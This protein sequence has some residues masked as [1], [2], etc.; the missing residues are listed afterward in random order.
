MSDRAGTPDDLAES[1]G[2]AAGQGPGAS[3]QNAGQ[4]PGVPSQIAWD[5][6]GAAYLESW[7]EANPTLAVAAGRHEFDGRL[8]DWS[9]DGLEREAARLR[10]ERRRAL[11]FDPAGL[12]RRRRLERE[13]LLSQIDA[14]LFWREEAGWPWRNPHFYA[15]A[16]DPNIYLTRDYAPPA[17]R[18]RAYLRW[19][20]AVPAAAAAMRANRTAAAHLRGARRPDLRRP[21]H[22]LRPRRARLLL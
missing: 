4:G 15:A 2:A 16:L 9:R 17:E 7:F 12:D 21:G 5:R 8:P 6:L 18:L 19:A 20:G 14:D 11:A 1:A 22:L 13:L 3:S 10:A